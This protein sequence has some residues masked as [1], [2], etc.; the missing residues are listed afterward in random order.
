MRK[1]RRG[2]YTRLLGSIFVALAMVTLLHQGGPL[3]PTPV[4]A[5]TIEV[6]S[7]APDTISNNGSCSLREAI[8]NANANNQSG[9]TDCEAGTGANDIIV[10]PAGLYTLAIAGNDEEDSL[11]G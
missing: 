11:T 6:D 5:A 3:G 2:T 8:I 1:S 9:S 7:N 4:E 10:V